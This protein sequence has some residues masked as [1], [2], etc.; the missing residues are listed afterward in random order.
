MTIWHVQCHHCNAYVFVDSVKAPTHCCHC[1]KKVRFS[2]QEASDVVN[3]TVCEVTYDHERATWYAEHREMFETA[4]AYGL[5]QRRI[6]D[7]N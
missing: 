4:F 2:I 1:G 3:S 7:E 6:N 5:L